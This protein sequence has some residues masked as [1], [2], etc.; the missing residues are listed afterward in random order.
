MF[1]HT[2]IKMS[3]KLCE[4]ALFQAKLHMK[5]MIG[6]SSAQVLPFL[7]N[8]MNFLDTVSSARPNWRTKNNLN[9]NCQRAKGR[10]AVKHGGERNWSPRTNTAKTT[11]LLLEG[12]PRFYKLSWRLYSSL[13]VPEQGRAIPFFI[14]RVGGTEGMTGLLT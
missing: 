7:G 4:V 10:D 9:T 1:V 8:L 12:F 2:F 14:G 13:S 6:R 5:L 11:K 3:I